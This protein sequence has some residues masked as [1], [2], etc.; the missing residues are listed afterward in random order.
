ML[1]TFSTEDLLSTILETVLYM[2]YLN[3][4]FLL[5]HF[6]FSF[7]EFKPQVISIDEEPVK[8]KN[9]EG[10][11]ILVPGNVKFDTGNDAGTAISLRLLEKLDLEPDRS[12]KY[13]V[14]GVGGVM[15]CFRVEISLRIRRRVFK[16][17]ALV[18]SVAG[19]TDL[20]IGNDIMT[21]LDKLN[22]SFG[23]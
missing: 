18:G 12:K 7:S 3:N 11:A 14:E 6:F 21:K 17:S 9:G 15:E 13:S 2:V 22:F 8:I 19:D 4:N 5:F 16:V 23:Q 1:F 20:L 10:K